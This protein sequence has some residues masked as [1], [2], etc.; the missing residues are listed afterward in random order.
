MGLD[1]R[2]PGS[3]PE[4]KA[5]APPLSHPGVPVQGFGF[6]SQIN[7]FGSSGN[8]HYHVAGARRLPQGRVTRKT[9]VS[10]LWVPLHV[11]PCTCRR[12]RVW[13]APASLPVAEDWKPLSSTRVG[14]NSQDLGRHR[15]WCHKNHLR[16]AFGCM[17]TNLGLEAALP[18]LVMLPNF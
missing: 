2:T 11:R 14:R 10:E 13:P 12:H 17:S 15:R 9:H 4:P 7:C 16:L 18:G 3:R 1:P 6:I 5:D 8:T